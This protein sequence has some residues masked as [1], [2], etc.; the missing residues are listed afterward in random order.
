[1]I[2][3][4]LLHTFFSC[5][6]YNRNGYI[7]PSCCYTVLAL[8][9]LKAGTNW[10]NIL[11]QILKGVL[12]ERYI[13]IQHK[14]KQNIVSKLNNKSVAEVIQPQ[15]VGKLQ[16]DSTQRDGDS[17]NGINSKNASSVNLTDY[18]STISNEILYSV[19]LSILHTIHNLR[20]LF[21]TVENESKF[22][23]AF[24]NYFHEMFHNVQMLQPSSVIA[25]SASFETFEITIS[26][27]M[28]F[29]KQCEDFRMTIESNLLSIYKLLLEKKQKRMKEKT[30]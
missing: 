12:M 7:L 23:V 3:E 10:E 29:F 9:D 1:M 20:L 21:H 13:A 6:D 8:L 27:V 11:Q 19:S 14:T 16:N 5:L 17:N 18:F 4:N 25:C 30:M 22:T 2:P 28:E 15:K 24:S 26:D